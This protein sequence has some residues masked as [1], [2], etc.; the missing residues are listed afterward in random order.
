MIFSGGKGGGAL[1]VGGM[2][3]V[4]DITEMCVA[5]F[6]VCHK[7][8]RRRRLNGLF[9]L[10]AAF[11]L[12]TNYI[13]PEKKYIYIHLGSFVGIV[14]M[15]VPLTSTRLGWGW[16]AEFGQHRET[17]YT[18]KNGQILKSTD[19]GRMYMRVICHNVIYGFVVWTHTRE[20]S[21]NPKP[22]LCRKVAAKGI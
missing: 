20:F 7:R 9:T 14:F 1:E 13:G 5:R 11:G 2:L 8:T 6:C 4:A 3:R 22:L 16:L 15:R 17:V 18:Y 12:N 10:K 21:P 19:W